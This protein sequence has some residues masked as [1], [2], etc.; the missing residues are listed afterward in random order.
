M[1]K[2]HHCDPTE[3]SGERRTSLLR[4][5]LVTEVS[6]RLGIRPLNVTCSV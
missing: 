1:P 5:I 2:F 3:L 4:S 6:L